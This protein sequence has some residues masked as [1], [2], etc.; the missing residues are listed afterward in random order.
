MGPT[1]D[2]VSN[3]GAVRMFST[4]KGGVTLGIYLV[5]LKKNVYDVFTAEGSRDLCICWRSLQMCS[6]YTQQ[7]TNSLTGIDVLLRECKLHLIVQF[8]SAANGLFGSYLFNVSR[9][10]SGEISKRHKCK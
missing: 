3:E 2:P 1:G 10:Q 9:R 6:F 4:Q 8:H 7:E 5:P